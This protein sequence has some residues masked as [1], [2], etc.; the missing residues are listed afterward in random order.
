MGASPRS[1]NG[2]ARLSA[3]SLQHV[4]ATCRCNTSLQHVAATRR[5]NMSNITVTTA[6][7][8]TSTTARICQRRRRKKKRSVTKIAQ[9]Y[10]A[11]VGT[12]AAAHPITLSRQLQDKQEQQPE[13][14]DGNNKLLKKT[15]NSKITN[16][17]PALCRS[18][19]GG[20]G[21]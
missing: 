6:Q 4:A 1:H 5:C 17:Q 21:T 14:V 8:K 11:I 16:N 9:R 20:G 18:F 15:A 12:A 2:T 19:C 10:C 13:F 3:P 7:Q